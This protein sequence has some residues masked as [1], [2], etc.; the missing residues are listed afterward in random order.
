MFGHTG[1][2]YCVD[3]FSLEGKGHI[4]DLHVGELTKADSN[5]FPSQ[6]KVI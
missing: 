6:K 3:S 2:I 4:E 1:H 5:L